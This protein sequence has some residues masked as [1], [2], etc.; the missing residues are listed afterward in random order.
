MSP[1]QAW[2]QILGLADINYVIYWLKKLEVVVLMPPKLHSYFTR[3]CWEDNNKSILWNTA[4][5][6]WK[7]LWK[8]S[9]QYCLL[10][11]IFGACHLPNII[12]LEQND[13]QAAHKLYLGNIENFLYWSGILF[14]NRPMGEQSLVYYCTLKNCWNNYRNVSL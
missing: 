6:I 12:A 5:C 13:N 3:L 11:R 2:K 8:G 9:I 14:C 10:T 4:M 7:S 1:W